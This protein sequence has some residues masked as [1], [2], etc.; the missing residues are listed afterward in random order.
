M[1][2]L[3]YLLFLISICPQIHAQSAAAGICFNSEVAYMMPALDGWKS[4]EK[5]GKLE[6]VDGNQTALIYSEIDESEKTPNAAQE[7]KKYQDFFKKKYPSEKISFETF[8]AIE[9]Y[10]TNI[11]FL[12]LKILGQK[13]G[14]IDLLLFTASDHTLY[15]LIYTGS[16]EQVFKKYLSTF[17]KYAKSIERTDAVVLA[18]ISPLDWA[19]YNS[20]QNAKKY[21]DY[22]KYVIAMPNSPVIEALRTCSKNIPDA[23]EKIFFKLNK[24]GE[25]E[26]AIFSP[27]SEKLNICLLALANKLKKAPVPPVSP[28]YLKVTMTK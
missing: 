3:F 15:K 5:C 13:N 12:P 14:Q 26:D 23:T 27:K 22:F 16:N 11:N 24:D 17:L 1:N 8:K 20:N 25:I 2:S 7:L 6:L 10:A 18:K 4:S 21:K 9:S 28:F 19:E